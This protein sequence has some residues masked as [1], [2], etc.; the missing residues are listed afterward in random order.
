MNEK[1]MKT[2]NR[3]AHRGPLAVM[4]ELANE[5]EQLWQKPWLPTFTFARRRFDK[6]ATTWMPRLD[7]FKKDN[8]LVVKADLPGIQKEDI[9]V[10]LEE[11]DL[12]LKG[13]R[14]EETKVEE[15][16]YY[17]AEC[18]YGSFYRRLPLGFA[19]VPETINAKFQDGILEVHV[20]M[21]VEA[22][23]EVKPIPVS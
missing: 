20:P 21:P 2:E 4:D 12:I 10:Y 11:G 15:E 22:K 17:R 7:V 6:E 8:D 5:L 14:K 3:P 1:M 9:Q 19:A 13:E 16:S 18:T 23:P